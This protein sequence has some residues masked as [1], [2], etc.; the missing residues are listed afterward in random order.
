MI[1]GYFDAAFPERRNNSSS[2]NTKAYL[3]ELDIS[4]DYIKPEFYTQWITFVCENI[5]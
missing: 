1:N 4:T 2:Y 5:A 3:A